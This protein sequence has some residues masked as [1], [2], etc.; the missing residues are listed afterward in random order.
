MYVNFEADGTGSYIY[1]EDS[2][3]SYY[4]V[5]F[6]WTLDESTMAFAFSDQTSDEYWAYLIETFSIVSNTEFTAE[7]DSEFGSSTMNLAAMDR[8]DITTYLPEY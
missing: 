5:T 4:L 3:S 6:N 1:R 2:Y 8:F 7:M